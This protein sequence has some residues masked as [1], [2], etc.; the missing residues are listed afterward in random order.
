MGATLPAVSTAQQG[1]CMAVSDAGGCVDGSIVDAGG[2]LKPGFHVN[3]IEP[4]KRYAHGVLGDAIEW[5]GLEFIYQGSAQH[6]P[7]VMVSLSLPASRVFEDIQPRLIDLDQDGSFEIVVVESHKNR[8]AQLA[9]YE[10]ISQP[11]FALKK[12]ASTPHI[13]TRFRWLAPIGAADFDDDGHIEIGY[14]DRPH[15]AKTLRLWRFKNG[16]LREVANLKGLTNHRIGQAE[17]PGGVRD[18]GQGP[19]MITANADWSQ[20]MAT[21]FNGRTLTARP[22]GP[23]KSNANLNQMLNCR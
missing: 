4:T 13:G 14:I 12:I 11:D 8:G 1:S 5:G 23:F 21:T 7:Y 9:V 22:L 18:C 6:G 17:I 16:K 10:L 20:I 2:V 3:F 19:E 15:L